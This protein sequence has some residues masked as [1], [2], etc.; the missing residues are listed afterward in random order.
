MN[1]TATDSSNRWRPERRRT[2]AATLGASLELLLQSTADAFS[3]CHLV[4]A[5]RNGL[6]H[7][8]VGDAAECHALAAFGPMLDRSL[9]PRTREMLTASLEQYV[10]AARTHAMLVRRVDVGGQPLYLCAVG[11]KESTLAVAV[12]RAASG[13]QRIFAA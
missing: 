3:L 4:L 12:Q 10:P 8:A 6:Q 11:P 2:R 5:D 13:A 9:D 7:A 1:Q